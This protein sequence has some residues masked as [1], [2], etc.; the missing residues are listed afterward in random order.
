MVF[1]ITAFFCFTFLSLSSEARGIVGSVFGPKH[2]KTGG[3]IRKK[4]N[5]LVRVPAYCGMV[6]GAVPPCEPVLQHL[7]I[8]RDLWYCSHTS[9]HL[10]IYRRGSRFPLSHTAQ[11][12]PTLHTALHSKPQVRIIRSFLL[13]LLLFLQ[14]RIVYL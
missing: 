1:L 5:K 11:C 6:R 3:H 10:F 13:I 9:I 12:T 4:T 2:Q 8:L 14:R 7:S